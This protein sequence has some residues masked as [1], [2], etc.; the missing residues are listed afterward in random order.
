VCRDIII[1]LS[2]GLTVPFGLTAG[3]AALG[4]SR[5]VVA[6]GIAE[7]ISGAISMGV[8]GGLSAQ[9]ERDHYRY[10]KGATRARV[11]RSCAGELEREVTE[12]LGCVGL[13]ES[14]C[15]R[16]AVGL[17]KVENEVSHQENDGKATTRPSSSLMQ[18]VLRTIARKPRIATDEEDSNR[19]RFSD[20][21]GLTPF[22]LKFG[23]GLEEVPTSRIF[24]SAFTIGTS[25]AIGGLFPLLPYFFIPNVRTALFWS[26]GVT[27]V[28]LVIFGVLKAYHTGGRIGFTGYFQNALQTLFV[29]FVAAGSAFA[30][31]AALET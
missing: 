18:T 14:L 7:L 19:L 20:E 6:G 8:G 29:G 30:I 26:I 23:E 16:V 17:M 24:I 10:L 15:R 3:L 13:E 1:G 28:V 5:V 2:D 9:A 31:C 27:A 4:N 21:V 25:Y 12:V 22:L 11:K